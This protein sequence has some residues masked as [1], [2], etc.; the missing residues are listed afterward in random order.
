M[1]TKLTTPSFRSM[2]QH[3]KY[4][5]LKMLVTLDSNQLELI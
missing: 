3:K 4:E 2:L 1:P 5:H